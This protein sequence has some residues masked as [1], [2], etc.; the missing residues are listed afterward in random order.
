MNQMLIRTIF[1]LIASVSLFAQCPQEL[2]TDPV[3]VSQ[4]SIRGIV[5]VTDRNRLLSKEELR[6]IRELHVM[7]VQIPGSYSKFQYAVQQ[8]VGQALNDET[9]QRLKRTLYEYFRGCE[10]PFV[11]IGV[12]EQDFSEGVV[13]VVVQESKLGKVSVV[14]NHWLPAKRV[15]KYFDLKL[16]QPICCNEISKDLNFVNRNPFRRVSVAYTPGSERNTTDVILEVQ[17]RRPYRFYVGFDN[18]GVVTTGRQRVFAGFSWDQVFNLDHTF[19]YQYTTNYDIKRFHANTLQY[20]V[21]LP[22]ETILNLYGGFSIVHADLPNPARHNKGTNAQVSARYHVPITPA[23]SFTQEWIVGFDWKNT[24][25][26]MEFVDAAPRFGHTVNLT[27]F[28]IGYQWG[29]DRGSNFIRSGVE[30]LF[31]PAQWLSNQTDADFQTLRPG[32]NNT[33]V[34]AVCFFNYRRALPR[35]TSYVFFMRGQ[36][37]S[38]ALLPSE[39]L[40][41]GGY[42]TVRGYDQRQYNADNGFYLSNEFHTAPFT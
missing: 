42:D 3:P 25:N 22:K 4:L 39:Q 26:T 36:W 41:I 6:S 19:F 13:Q 27:Q 34:Y 29:W 16:G 5:L 28:V 21:M 8:Y 9:L 17:D 40:G 18:S 35:S 32:A 11:T 15:S 1:I 12:P 38:T 14:G 2:F 10:H 31:S 23:R 7:G 37:S 24:N 33:W 30:T 20:M